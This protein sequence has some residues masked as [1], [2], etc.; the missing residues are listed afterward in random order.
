MAGLQIP[1]PLRIIRTAPAVLMVLPIP[2]R[3]ERL[4]PSER[5]DIQALAG[6]EIAASR[7][8]MHVH[9]PA[10]VAVLDRCPGVAVRLEP[11]P[12]GFLELV[13]DAADLP[14]ARGV[15]RCPR[16]EA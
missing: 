16:E 8:D 4:F 1:R 9:A 15:L 3:P 2:Q 6:R 7:Q 14:V 13:Q 5:R 10:R 12:G 11:R